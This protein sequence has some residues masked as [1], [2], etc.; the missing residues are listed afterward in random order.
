MASTLTRHNS[1]VRGYF[2]CCIFSSASFQDATPFGTRVLSSCLVVA[3]SVVRALGGHEQLRVIERR[4]RK[5]RRLLGEDSHE[6][7]EKKPLCLI[8]NSR[9]C[10]SGL[11][12]VSCRWR[13]NHRCRM[14]PPD[15]LRHCGADGNSGSIRNRLP[16][17]AQVA[18]GTPCT[19]CR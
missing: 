9:Y 8:R 14:T 12:T 19:P 5:L 2:S 18:L 17:D 16:V 11:G 13:H 3:G 7:V 1:D 10:I 15:W 6:P 4:I